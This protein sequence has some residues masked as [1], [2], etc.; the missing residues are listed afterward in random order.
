MFTLLILFL[1]FSSLVLTIQSYSPN[2]WKA[3]KKFH[4]CSSSCKA[5]P[6]ENAEEMRPH[7]DD[8]SPIIVKSYNHKRWKLSYMYK[9]PSPGYEFVPP[10]VFV[11]PVGIGL[12][13]WF[14]TKVMKEYGETNEGN[15]ALYAVDLI[16]CGLENGSDPWDPQKQG[17]FFPLSWVEG[18]ETF[19]LNVALPE[20]NSNQS[21][22]RKLYQNVTNQ[23][24]GCTVVVQGGLASVGILLS[25]RNP[26]SFVSKL[27]LTSPPTYD[28][29]VT[30]LSE[31][32]VGKNYKFLTSSLCLNLGFP[33]LESR[34]LI[35][36]FS[37]L[38]LFDNNCDEA[39]LDFT[40][41]GASFKEARTP[42][43]AFNSGLLGT[44]SYEDE[45]S[46][47][48]Q[49][50]LLICGNGD[51]RNTKRIMYTTKMKN[52]NL[53]TLDGCNV[54]PWEN[55]RDV[56]RLIHEFTMSQIE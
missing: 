34:A 45:I 50:V 19:I 22:Q 24:N 52:C 31:V 30:P 46:S 47:L 2:L 6:I 5:I 12:S 55:E 54:L 28:E 29:M 21:K 15:P 43:Q 37:D 23:V 56:V 39:W 53:K 3:S 7:F 48:D 32:E 20:Y 1:I 36:L 42:V 27:I 33:I 35:R 9:P 8:D 40:M 17:L 16:G 44:R 38:F 11:H 41:V 49:K 13:S 10:I 4:N 25:S 26:I 51:K 14:W 18:V